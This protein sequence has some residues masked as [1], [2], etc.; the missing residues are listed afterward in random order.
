MEIGRPIPYADGGRSQ[1]CL[2]GYADGTRPKM[3]GRIPMRTE[4]AKN[5]PYISAKIWPFWI[6]HCSA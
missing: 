2:I 4:L 1:I 6:G 3:V 5:R